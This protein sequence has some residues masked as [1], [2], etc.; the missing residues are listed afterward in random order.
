M[1]KL[2][3]FNEIKIALRDYPSV[4]KSKNARLSTITSYV[5]IF[6]ILVAF[7]SLWIGIVILKLVL[8]FLIALIMYFFQHKSKFLSVRSEAISV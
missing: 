2:K 6:S 4:I 8:H 5:F 1:Q 3:K 7:L